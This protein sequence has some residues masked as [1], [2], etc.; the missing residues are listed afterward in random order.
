[1]K[2]LKYFFAG[3]LTLCCSAQAM[4]QDVKSQVEAITK[5]IIDNQNNPAAVKE[6]VK[7]FVKSNKKNATA[8]AGLGR[9]YLDIKD[10]L[11]TKKYAEMAMKA[12]KTKAD[13]YLLMG[14]LAAFNDN[15]GEA[16]MWY[17]TA[18]TQDPK[19]PTGYIKYARV[20]Q[21]VD[22]AGAEEKL[23][24]LVNIDPNYPVDAEIAH[25]YYANNKFAK[26]LDNYQ[27]VD[28]SKLDDSKLLEYSMAALLLGKSDVS[29]EVSEYGVQK[30]PRSA[31][32]NRITFYNYTDLKNY[33]K[34]LQY[35]DALFNRCD[36][37]KFTARDYLYLGHA[38]KGAGKVEDAVASFNKSYELD[39]TQNDV[40]KLISDTYLDGKNYD[41]SVEYLQKYI[42][43]ND[44]KKVS[45]YTALARI[46]MYMADD[47]AR[48]TEALQ[49]ADKA[50]A[51]LAEAFP[52]NEDYA[53]YQRAH[54]HHAL[55]PDVKEGEAKP[56]YEKYAQLLESRTER[57][58]AENSTL[59]EAYNYLSV[60]YIQNDN[61]S[62]AKEYA[63]KLLEIQPENDTAK[64]IIAI[65][66]K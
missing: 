44:Q 14:D 18:I 54:V 59:A 48:K 17:E 47:P 30:K 7:E 33:D 10:T 34:A 65:P 37:A 11:N 66:D 4:A 23:R 3:A 39:N 40:L 50:Y 22:A 28:K 8:L 36:S 13:G 62:T 51:D 56:Y 6:Q 19:S 43:N 25:M 26:A 38:N 20:Y 61:V 16:A 1:M 45:D 55:N 53:T 52:N 9:A 5:V 27:K 42:A 24:Q 57:S 32:F 31:G 64:Q 35:A 58:S 15:G 12:E 46:Y 41:K 21:K 49:K 29:V 63:N 2:V 60:Y